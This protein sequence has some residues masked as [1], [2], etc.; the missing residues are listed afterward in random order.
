MGP[1]QC[2]AGRLHGVLRHLSSSR[3]AVRLRAG[4]PPQPAR[5]VQQRGVPPLSSAPPGSA[6]AISQVVRQGQSLTTGRPQAVRLALGSRGAKTAIPAVGAAPAMLSAVPA[7]ISSAPRKRLTRPVVALASR[8]GPRLPIRR[9]PNWKAP[10]APTA[11]TC[12]GGAASVSPGSAPLVASGFST[13]RCCAA[14]AVTGGSRTLGTAS[15][16]RSAQLTSGAFRPA[17]DPP[18]CQQPSHRCGQLG[19]PPSCQRS[20]HS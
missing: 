6:A 18:S 5:I 20:Q 17:G 12:S 14:L 4:M 1:R 2:R 16:W 7:R 10:S 3:E 9:K 15:E 13:R 8:P 11:T 19:G